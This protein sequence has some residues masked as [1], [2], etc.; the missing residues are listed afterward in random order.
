MI[1]L[2]FVSPM[3]QAGVKR[4]HPTLRRIRRH[5][6]RSGPFAAINRRDFNL[7]FAF[8][9]LPFLNSRQL[10]NTGLTSKPM[11][12]REKFNSHLHASQETD[13]CIFSEAQAGPQLFC[14]EQ[15]SRA[16]IFL[17]EMQPSEVPEVHREWSTR[18][19]RYTMCFTTT[20]GKAPIAQ[21]L[22]KR[23]FT[24]VCVFNEPCFI[25]VARQ[26]Q[27]PVVQALKK[28]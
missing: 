21:A 18:P 5:E 9:A 27:Q 13:T 12:T 20:L 8:T 22:R 25:R 24:I 23:P 10:H 3:G 14:A 28:I 16:A 2:L 15:T 19:V 4:L 11:N 6:Q 1:L 7:C 26:P 17:K